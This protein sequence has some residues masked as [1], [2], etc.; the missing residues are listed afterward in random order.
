ML[1]LLH[2]PVA[3]PTGL[4]GLVAEGYALGHFTETLSDG[5]SAVWHGGQGYG[6][7]T[8]VHIVPET[9]DAIVL[10]A[11]SQRAWPLFAHI[12][13]AWSGSLGVAPVRMSRIVWAAP[14]AWG[15]IVLALG[16]AVLLVAG[17]LS[18]RG[19][20]PGSGRRFLRPGRPG[21]V[22]RLGALAVGIGLVGL[23][24]WASL[25][26]YLFLFSI[27][28]AATGWLGMALALLGGAL[29]VWGVVP[30]GDGSPE[31]GDAT[32]PPASGGPSKLGGMGLVAAL[33]AW[34]APG[35]EAQLPLVHI[36]GGWMP[37][38]DVTRSLSG[39]ATEAR[40]SLLRGSVLI[41]LV[42]RRENVL[43]VPRLSGSRVGVTPRPIDPRE[44]VWVEALYDLDLELLGQVTLSPRDRLSVVLSP[45]MAS[46]VRPLRSDHLTV[47]AAALL[48]RASRPDRTWGGGVSLT[49]AFGQVRVVP[50][51]AYQWQGRR[52]QA[53]LLAP[54]R[55]DLFWTPTAR[56]ALGVQAMIDGNVYGLG[57]AGTLQD[58]RVRYSL[59]DVGPVIRFDPGRGLRLSASAGISFR[60]R[61]EV[62][63][64]AGRP[65][66][67]AALSQGW[68]MGIGL[69]WMLP[70]GP[71]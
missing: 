8:H 33:L 36:E 25:Q 44:P 31:G 15:V 57:R 54:A 27:L 63:D 30:A 24:V 47:Q 9:G 17:V 26:D 40:V 64:A 43:V 11:N 50:L 37:P 52:F 49:N 21:P 71:G 23:V 12:L 2:T 34:G 61:L 14:V 4:Y 48:T 7:M 35:V 59:A 16:S 58:G 29:V 53:D 1:A 3:R 70:E 45:G 67:D 19:M 10:L 20:R 28:P 60:R 18:R 65:V 69:S 32:R 56:L 22:P 68:R 42:L 6:W 62:E 38:S 39:P 5:R 46:D 13:R 41:P 66:E 51:V 55:G